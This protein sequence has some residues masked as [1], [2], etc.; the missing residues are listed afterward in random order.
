MI[1][2][3]VALAMF[4]SVAHA[5]TKEAALLD[6]AAAI[7]K[8]PLTVERVQAAERATSALDE[9][10]GASANS[11]A[12]AHVML[13]QAYSVADMD[14]AVMLHA[15]TVLAIEPHLE[16]A[17]RAKFAP[18]LTATYRDLAAVIA[19]HGDAAAALRLLASAPASLAPDLADDVA[20]YEMVGRPAPPLTAPQWFNAPGSEVRLGGGSVTVLELTAWW[21]GSCVRSYPTLLSLTRSYGDR[22]RVVLATGLLGYFRGDTAITAAAE[23][24]KLRAYFTTEEHFT[25]PIAVGA[26]DHDAIAE[27]Y[28]GA[29]IPQI[30][31]IDGHGIVRRVLMGWD[32]GNAQRV[33]EAIRLALGATP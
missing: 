13:L 12:W 15:N 32:A 21:C 29:A 10:P 30:V 11:R 6:T 19:G 27:A 2:L 18:A 14:S 31:V 17:Q 23:T 4:A 28:H 25:C 5:Q 3:T 9:L 26:R 7:L 1:R 24:E 16:P 33:D 20:R 8:G 22:V